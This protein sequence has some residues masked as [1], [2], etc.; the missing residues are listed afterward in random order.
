MGQLKG[1]VED[2]HPIGLL[3]LSRI[4]TS[5]SLRHF[6]LP[7]LGREQQDVW[8]VSLPSSLSCHFPLYPTASIPSSLSNFIPPSPSLIPSSLYLSPPYLSSFLLLPLSSLPPSIS[9]LPI[10]LHSSFS[11]SHPFLP[12]P[13][14]L[15]IFI[16]PSPF[17]VPSLPLSLPLTFSLP[18]PSLHY[19]ITPLL[20]IYFPHF[21]CASPCFFTFSPSSFS[22]PS[23]FPHFSL[24]LLSDPPAIPQTRLKVT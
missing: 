8:G 12:S 17:F 15:S 24:F 6:L 23:F 3:D 4:T 20:P 21:L 10:Y 9:L 11:L 18:L 22:P 13:S 16:P 2:Q 5:L 14:S 1:V 7:Y 19:S